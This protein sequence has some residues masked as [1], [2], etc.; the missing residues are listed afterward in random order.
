MKK[1][2]VQ[3]E[4]DRISVRR[5]PYEDHHHNHHL[6]V[7]TLY[8]ADAAT[9]NMLCQV[10][11]SDIN[12]KN[13]ASIPDIC[14]SMKQQLLSMVEWAKL[15]PSFGELPLD[16]QVA[17]L[18]ANACKHLL[19]GVARRSVRDVLILSNN[20]TLTRTCLDIEQ[21]K[22]TCRILDEVAQVMREI[23]VDESELACLLAIVF[24]DPTCKGISDSHKVRSFRWQV[25][26]NLEDYINDRQYDS[27]GRFGEMLLLLQNL[28]SISYQLIE[29]VNFV[30]FYSGLKLDS[31][32]H[33]ML[34][35]EYTDSP[36]STYFSHP[37]SY[38]QHPPCE[39]PLAIAQT[40]FN[41]C[42]A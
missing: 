14:E 4:R 40:N 6:S 26:I 23:Q 8:K 1:E 34:L 42:S 25:Q 36:Q 7:T 21:N 3:N 2:A 35:Q 16:D 17:L 9:K 24:F 30:R 32:I 10:T 5:T 41:P 27:R 12:S 38:N 31:L 11:N 29:Q 18:R 39:W 13:I 15:I 20:S 28:Q 19:L 37:L 33:E 22:V